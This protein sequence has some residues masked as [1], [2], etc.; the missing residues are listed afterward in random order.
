MQN[1]NWED[2]CARSSRI[3]EMYSDKYSIEGQTFTFKSRRIHLHYLPSLDA[4][5]EA[6]A[7]YDK[8]ME[9]VGA[10]LF[11]I[12]KD[13]CIF[14]TDTRDP[15]LERLYAIHEKEA[16]ELAQRLWKINSE[17]FD[18]YF[19]H[20]TAMVLAGSFEAAFGRTYGDWRH[21]LT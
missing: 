9:T 11:K 5:I 15:N 16:D 3:A 4:I 17:E 18:M 2:D 21:S 10:A 6:S 7:G 20:R 13:H 12:E 14:L 1:E 8:P 19:S